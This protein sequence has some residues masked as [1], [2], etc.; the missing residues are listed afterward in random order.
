M[1]IGWTFAY[2]R[3]SLFYLQADIF[4]LS[5]CWLVP[6]MPGFYCWAHAVFYIS[7]TFSIPH[8]SAR[9]RDTSSVLLDG[10]T[11][12][13]HPLYCLFHAHFN[14]APTLVLFLLL[15]LQWLSFLLMLQIRTILFQ[16]GHIFLHFT[17]RQNAY[18]FRNS[19]QLPLI[20]LFPHSVS[21]L[22]IH[23]ADF[24]LP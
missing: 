21:F 17:S 2:Y 3:V 7:F 13:P 22:R 11:V 16:R 23:G 20:H 6:R 15:L 24:Q 8:S 1:F 9:L 4:Q 10:D 14:S 12:L 19:L 5:L 18:N